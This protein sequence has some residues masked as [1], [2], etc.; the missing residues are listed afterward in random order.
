MTEIKKR[1]FVGIVGLVSAGLFSVGCSSSSSTPGTGGTTG[2]AGTT[3]STAGT[4]GS[5]GTTG[6]A[7][8]TGTGGAT[9]ACVKA[10]TSGL[11]ADFMG[12]GG[13]EVVGGLTGFGGVAM[14]T[15]T[16]T[17]NTLEIKEN[18]PAGAA[19]QYVG[20]VIY[21]NN[22]VDASAFTGVKFNLG[23]SFSGCT[24]QFSINDVQHDDVVTD[25]KG[26]CT[27]GT[28]CYSPQA[29]IATVMPTAV[30]VMEPFI[31][32]AGG[33][34]SAPTDPSMLTGIQ[35]QFTIA[36]AAEGGAPTSCV[37]D[38]KLSDITFY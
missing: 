12:D 35:W 1:A 27:L 21:F 8:T 13:I 4:T 9:A 23:G 37:A 11:I 22:C 19:P 38:L 26:S 36:P 3:G 28:M 20:T 33:A 17:N 10:S 34:P 7:G 15:F 14:P 5:G 31:T 6:S 32:T 24:I 2:H 25:P 30:P 16:T 29:S 18:N